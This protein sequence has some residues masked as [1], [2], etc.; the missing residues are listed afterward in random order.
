MAELPTAPL[1]SGFRRNDVGHAEMTGRGRA[2]IVHHSNPAHPG[3]NPAHPGSK[4]TPPCLHGG[5]LSF[6]PLPRWERARV[7]V[8]PY[9]AIVVLSGKNTQMP[10]PMIMLPSSDST[11]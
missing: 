4:K 1:D 11:R 8:S 3:S 2:I 7:R 9:G 5:V 10:L 6:S